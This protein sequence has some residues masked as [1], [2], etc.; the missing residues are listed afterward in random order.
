MPADHCCP[1]CGSRL[2]SDLVQG[3]CPACL[4]RAGLEPGSTGESGN[5]E[6]TVSFVPSHLGPVLETLAQA[7]GS[8]PRILLPDTHP[9]DRGTAVVKPASSEMPSQAERSQRYQ[10]FG[11]IARGG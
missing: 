4:L 1:E 8:I 10:L 6:V 7:V 2:P 5:R 9:D 3:R 11:E